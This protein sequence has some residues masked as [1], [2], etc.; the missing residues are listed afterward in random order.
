MLNFVTGPGSGYPWAAQLDPDLASEIS[1][2]SVINSTYDTFIANN[3]SIAGGAI[4]STDINSTHVTCLPVGGDDSTPE[5]VPLQLGCSSPA[6]QG[7]TAW[8]GPAMGYIPSNISVTPATFPHYV[9]NGS[10][11]LSMI[12]HAQDQAG[13][14]VKTG[15]CASPDLQI[16]ITCRSHD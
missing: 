8:Y 7:N 13:N 9:S 5:S 1:N 2:C 11:T 3:A 6:W 14:I 12:V 15:T 10:D 4:F 16:V